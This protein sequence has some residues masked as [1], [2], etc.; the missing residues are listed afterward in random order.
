MSRVVEISTLPALLKRNAL[1]FGDKK[2]ALREKEFGIW[3]AITWKEYWEKVRD[4]TLGLHQ[5]GFQRGDKLAVIGDNRPEWFYSELAAQSLGG[6]VVGIYPDSHLDQVEYII[7][8]SDSTFVMVGDQEQADKILSIK[9]K[10]P[11]IRKAI[12]DDPKGMRSYEDP[13]FHFLKDVQKSGRE[14]A[15]T[16]PTLFDEMIDQVSPEDVGTIVYTSGTTGL[17]KGSM[18]THRNMTSIGRFLDQVDEARET[19]NYVSFLPLSWIGEQHFALYWSLTKAFTV[20]FPEKVETAQQNIR[21]IG[22]NIMLAPPRIWE[23]MCSD[24]QVKIQDAAWIKRMVYKVFLSIGYRVTGFKLKKK[25]PPL[26]LRFLKKIGFWLLFRSL[27]NYLGLAR[28]RHVY[29]GGAPLGPEIFNMFQA[30]DINIKQAYGMTEQSGGTMI[31]RTDDI[32]LDTVGKP[33]PGIEIKVSDEGELLFRGDTIFKGYYKDPGATEKALRDGWFH[34]GDAALIDEDGQVIIIDRMSDV[35][36]LADGGKFS[37][38]LIENKLKFSPYIIDA[39]VIGQDQPFITAMINIDMNNVGKWAESNQLPY[40]TFTDLSQKDKVYDLIEKEVVRI[41]ETLPK[42]A[43]VKRFVLLYKELDADDEELTRTRK[44][45]RKF[46]A[47]K[48]KHLI[49]ALYGDQEELEVELNIRYR[50]GKEFRMKT[51]VKVKQVRTP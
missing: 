46:V 3:Q 5:V 33:L 8:H 38:Q 2:V 43:Q 48:Y 11:K 29:T 39:L 1:Q 7:N 4:F 36:K 12:V 20:N 32:R 49:D 19:D 21:E 15:N 40:T 26:S 31:H 6:A 50:D 47:E 17:P 23:K 41:N 28:V 35:M 14:L 13:I 44:V 27:K 51:R 37:P 10:C 18:I 42:V 45:R 16:N 24:I 34:T 22:P 30:L 25:T 9:E